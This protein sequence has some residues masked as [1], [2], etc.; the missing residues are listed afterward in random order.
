[1]VLVVSHL[2]PI[3]GVAVALVLTHAADRATVLRVRLESGLIMQAVP[4]IPN[5]AGME[6]RF[7]RP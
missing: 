3:V 1:M 5:M 6:W 4:S 7:N 2:W